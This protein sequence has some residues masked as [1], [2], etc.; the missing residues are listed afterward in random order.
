MS[1]RM[2][3]RLS[4]PLI[5]IGALALVLTSIQ[6]GPARALPNL[7][8]ALD[9]VFGTRPEETE[10]PPSDGAVRPMPSEVSARAR[11]VLPASPGARVASEVDPSFAVPTTLGDG[12]AATTVPTADDQATAELASEAVATEF[13]ANT[14]VE[15]D[16]V[17]TEGGL[18]DEILLSPDPYFYES[19]GR[20]DPFVSLVAGE[21]DDEAEDEDRERPENLIVVGILW[22][23]G[24][25]YALVETME[26][27]SLVL[28][29]GGRYGTATVTRINPDGIVL[30]VN[31]YGVGRTVQLQVS[32]GRKGSK[33][34]DRDR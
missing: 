6:V 8:D 27:R 14:G 32:E 33:K 4:A 24:D 11:S 9:K 17:M 18:L 23:D 30:Y 5:G 19:L 28:R 10:T 16:S 1:E 2:F 20:R 34:N 15:G 26:G 22:G 12:P 7:K 13:M 31:D 3:S 25:R 21:G 29:E